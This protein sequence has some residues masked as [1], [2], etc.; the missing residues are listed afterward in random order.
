MWALY[1]QACSAHLTKWRT[2]TPAVAFG[3]EVD[4]SD[5]SMV[6]DF[7]TTNFTPRPVKH[8]AYSVN[9]VNETLAVV[10]TDLTD[11]TQT[12]AIDQN[13][14]VRVLAQDITGN[15]GVGELVSG[16]DGPYQVW[17]YMLNHSE[18]L[19]DHNLLAALFMYD[20]NDA[21]DPS[22]A[23]T[24]SGNRLSYTYEEINYHSGWGNELVGYDAKLTD[25][26]PSDPNMMG[27][28]DNPVNKP[29]PILKLGNVDPNVKSIY[30]AWYRPQ[31]AFDFKL[32]LRNA[33]GELISSYEDRTKTALTGQGTTTNISTLLTGSYGEWNIPEIQPTPSFPAPS[34]LNTSITSAAFDDT[35]NIILSGE[36]VTS[37]TG[38][39]SYKALATTQTGLSNTQVRN[40]MNNVNYADAVVSDVA[41]L[42]KYKL[43]RLRMSDMSG[44][45]D[46]GHFNGVD[47]SNGLGKLVW[48]NPNNAHLISAGQYYGLFDKN[49]NDLLANHN[50]DTNYVS[51]YDQISNRYT[52]LNSTD[53]QVPGKNTTAFTIH[54]KW[55][56]KSTNSA[57]NSMYM[58]SFVDENSYILIG[59][60]NGLSGDQIH[61]FG[62]RA[63]NSGNS[64]PGEFTIEYYTGEVNNGVH[65]T[66]AWKTWA[67]LKNPQN[68]KSVQW[69]NIVEGATVNAV[70][71]LDTSVTPTPAPEWTFGTQQIPKVLDA[72]NQ[73]VPAE[74]VNY[75][76]VYLY[77]TDGT[78]AH[79]AMAVQT[80]DGTS[81][82]E[83]ESDVRISDQNDTNKT[84]PHQS[85]TEPS[86]SYYQILSNG[87]KV[88]VST[89]QQN[90]VLWS[91]G[92]IFG[93]GEDQ[94]YFH[95]N[96]AYLVYEFSSV[97]SNI[98][99][100]YMKNGGG[101][102]GAS[103]DTVIFYYYDGTS[104]VQVSNQSSL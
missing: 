7:I 58:D 84:A 12:Q 99:S 20:T 43:W 37:E 91:P 64:V 34:T 51:L 79:D 15:V 61:S 9:S 47:T 28:Y 72:N 46:S 89:I 86:T 35:G 77:G 80:I 3:S 103:C 13:A 55:L 16:P 104:Y 49:D 31:Y 78:P 97:K 26:P 59:F 14:Q 81:Y 38:V 98:H 52:M 60:E 17:L 54:S 62:L 8:S 90:A 19:V 82:N 39:T 40:L 101:A 71:Q 85:G 48:L 56:S 33:S 75:A 69:T 65:D 76:N 27:F 53:F 63:N 57:A 4:L 36:V 68:I 11:F 102:N 24:E 100:V 22:S 88:H 95:M 45:P 2:C 41:G 1:R 10:Y 18:G 66:T 21:W 50:L 93:M 83:I 44:S 96:T 42:K 23:T 32:E 29:L 92:K 94:M 74:S 5:N 73:I 67:V 30:L 6:T 70:F 25:S 87:D